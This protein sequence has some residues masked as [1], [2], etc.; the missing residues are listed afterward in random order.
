MDL[1]RVLLFTG[2]LLGWAPLWAQQVLDAP[3]PALGASD[4]TY[5]LDAGD[6]IKVNVFNQPDLSGEF[7]L[8]SK[9]QFVMPLIGRVDAE[10][11]TAARLETLLVSKY[12]PDY[13]VSP[14]IFV[15]VLN[16]RPYYL[17]GEAL[18]TGAFPYVAGMTYLTAIAT[19]GG[20]TYRA[21]KDYVYV[22]RADDPQQ[23]EI[24]LSVEEKIQPGDIIRI[25]ERLF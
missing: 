2:C 21:K 9:G 16:Y 3:V 23:K 11:L 15:Q 7:Q 18:K 10:G 19:A 13:L 5:Q 14:R 12:K 6:R 4:A 25:A 1:I 24:K 20:F 17:I 8:D 22:I